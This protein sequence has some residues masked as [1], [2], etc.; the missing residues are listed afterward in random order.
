MM[1]GIIAEIIINI[2]CSN[3]VD[4]IFNTDNWDK[5]FEWYCKKAIKLREVVKRFVEYD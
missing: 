2:I 4:E 1:F 3:A 5:Y